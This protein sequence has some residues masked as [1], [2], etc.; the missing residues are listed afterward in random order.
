MRIPKYVLFLCAILIG[1]SA[2]KQKKSKPTVDKKPVVEDLTKKDPKVDNPTTKTDGFRNIEEDPIDRTAVKLVAQ[3]INLA[4]GKSFSLNIPE[5]YEIHVAAEGMNRIRF[6]AESPDQRLFIPDMKTLADNKKGKIYILDD[7]DKTTNKFKKVNVWKSGLRNPNSIQFYKDKGGQEWLYV[8]LTD[9]LV[10]YKYTHGEMAPSS[11]PEKLC[12]F[13]GYGLSYKYGGWHLTR[14]LAFHKD[15]LYISV[16]SSCN[17][18]EEKKEEYM[19]ATVVKMDPNGQNIKVFAPG[20]R[21]AVDIGWVEGKF[22]ATN[23]GPDHLGDDTPNDHFYQLEEGRHYGWPYCYEDNGQIKE[24]DPKDQSDNKAAG[25]MVKDSWASKTIDCAKDVRPA[26]ALFEAHGSPLGFEYFNHEVT[27][28]E[29]KNYF[30]AA[31]HGS[32]VVRLGKGYSLVRFKKGLKPE[33]VVNGFLQNGN[34]VG[35]PCDV[36]SYGK[37]GFLFSDDHAGVIYYVKKK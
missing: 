20:V 28:P 25:K 5:G 16:G 37:D 18:C 9:S 15:E 12:E 8:A 14:T 23:M 21:N 13:P 34:R 30:V 17:L 33:P 36:F 4:N 35:R 27:L 22:Y 29:L 11:P 6:F 2:C 24:E 32:G 10:R 7:F 19:R 3:N 26:Y 1:T 31:L